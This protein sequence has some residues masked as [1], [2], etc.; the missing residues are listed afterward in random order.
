[1]EDILAPIFESSTGVKVPVPDPQ[2]DPQ[3]DFGGFIDP[4]GGG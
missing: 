3:T 1:V 4:N 2:N